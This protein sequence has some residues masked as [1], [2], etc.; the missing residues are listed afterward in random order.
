M[1][2]QG[3]GRTGPAQSSQAAKDSQT[4]LHS[5]WSAVLIT[6]AL[7]TPAAGDAASPMRVA[8]KSTKPA[9]PAAPAAQP[10]APAAQPAAPAAQPAAPAAQPAAPA[11]PAAPPAPPAPG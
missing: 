5:G 3:G 10:A 6:L 4:M 7:A 8:Q 2:W 9:Q 11:A 1:L